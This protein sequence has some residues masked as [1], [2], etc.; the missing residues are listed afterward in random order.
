M[1]GMI[2]GTTFTSCIGYER[3]DASHTGI[4]VNKY[5]D[6]KGVDAVTEVTGAIWYNS[7]KTDIYEW[8]TYVQTVKWE[9]EQA[10]R[11][12]SEDGLPVSFGVA[13]NYMVEQENTIRVFK[14]FRK[15]LSELEPSVIR[16]YCRDGFNTAAA[17]FS[18]EDLYANRLA[19][20]NVADSIVRSLLEK[21]GFTIEK[22]TLVSDIDLP[23]SVKDNI[24]A[25]VNAKQLALKKQDELAQTTADAEKKI[26]QTRGV[27]VSMRDM[28]DAERYAYEQKQKSLTSLLVQQQFIEKWDGVLPV[29]GEVPT[30]F[31]T[32]SK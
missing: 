31:K 2:I 12:T 20:F 16:T 24:E 25:K 11:V 27:T 14:K 30:L 4:R 10:F 15:D 17:S 22:V 5:G 9:H 28:A 6:E 19:Y 7:V 1:V 32:V 26:E 8:P 23:Q 3:I 18:A 21:E 13:L 29:Y